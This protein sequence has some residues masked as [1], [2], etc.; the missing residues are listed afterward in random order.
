[1]DA[2]GLRCREGCCRKLTWEPPARAPPNPGQPRAASGSSE[3][4]GGLAVN[5]VGGPG[6]VQGGGWQFAGWGLAV[7]RMGGAQVQE[8]QS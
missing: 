1:M 5:R 6:S 8:E 4:G 3:Q 2:E 7:C